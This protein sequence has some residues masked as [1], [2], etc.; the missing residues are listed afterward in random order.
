[1][2]Q[3]KVNKR[4]LILAAA[5]PPRGKGGGPAASYFIA[6]GLKDAGFDVNVV[7][8]GDANGNEEYEGLNVTIVKSP[9]IYWD[10]LHKTY[11][12]WKKLIWHVL[13]N[14]NPVAYFR[15]GSIIKKATPDIVVTISIENINVATWL[16]AKSLGIPIVHFAQS[17]FLCCWKGSLFKECQNCTKQC[18]DCKVMST[19]KK[20]LSNKVD[21]VIGE[22]NFILDQHK[23]L[24][25]FK[26]ANAV[27]IPGPI[28][29][30]TPND[31][32][33]RSGPLVVGY[34]G[35]L[36]QHKGLDILA[37]AASKIGED[38]NIHFMIAGTSRSDAYLNLLKQ[39]V[40]AA[41][42]SFLGWVEPE[43][44]YP[45][46]DV[47]I[48]PSVWKEPFGRIVVEAM[49]YGIPIIA[50]KSGGLTENI[51][52]GENGF[53]YESNDSTALANLIKKLSLNEALRLELSI[54]SKTLSKEF[55]YEN[56]V[57]RLLQFFSEFLK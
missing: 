56:F 19:G 17:Y 49:S 27:K 13:E 24:G 28:D 14:F 33:P 7:T 22:T 2:S 52:E 25:Y 31:V 35:V 38:A 40:G 20:W 29:E 21:A 4:I 16:R 57:T 34:M 26:Q 54:K 39:K 11:P 55:K 32:K 30:V 41:N 51:V 47:L 6:K 43:K 45:K 1:M 18:A 36:E 10:Y 12:T 53:L 37:D 9:N 42:V 5:F 15:I 50:A 8:V 23:Q 44:T 48:V 3:T 46:F